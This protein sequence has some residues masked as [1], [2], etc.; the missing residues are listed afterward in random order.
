MVEFKTFSN[1][2]PY[3]EVTNSVSSAKIA[4]QGAHI[5]EYKKDGKNELLWLSSLAQFEENKPIRGGI[6]ICWPW[7]G[8]H[9]EPSLPQHGFARISLF[10]FISCDEKDDITSVVTLKLTDSPKSKILWDFSFELLVTISISKELY[11]SIKTTNTDIK[12]FKITEALHTYLNVE[13]ILDA[14][15]FG[16]KK[17][18]YFDQLSK[19]MKVQKNDLHI[20]QEIDRIYI[21]PNNKLT[22]KEKNRTIFLQN[23]HSNSLVIW[24]PWREKVKSIKDMQDHEYKNMLCIESANVLDDSK[25]VQPDR[26]ITL[27]LKLSSISY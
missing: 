19:T 21:N 14:E 10:S 2:F 17:S 26:S 20:D 16:V 9:S 7:F 8:P 22:L 3:I 6:P 23:S 4:L 13:N 18:T 15:V 11:V 25:I 1:G 24:N 27:S 5:F 12:E